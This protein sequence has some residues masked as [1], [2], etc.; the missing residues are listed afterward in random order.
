MSF[1]KPTHYV[2][3]AGY[4]DDGAV[5]Y[6]RTDGTWTGTLADAAPWTTEAEADAKTAL[7]KKQERIVCDPYAFGVLVHNGVIDPMTAREGIRAQGPTTPI[8]RP[9][10]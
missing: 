10:R 7:A 8:R 6:L 3:T 5:A 4:T 2:V 9:D 1:A